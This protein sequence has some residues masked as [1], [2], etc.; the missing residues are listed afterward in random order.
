MKTYLSPLFLLV[1]LISMINP[2]LAGE[3]VN[4]TKHFNHASG[5][6]DLGLTGE[7]FGDLKNVYKIPVVLD[8]VPDN[9]FIN[10][11][12]VVITTGV[13]HVSYDPTEIFLN[14]ESIKE[15]DFRELDEGS[16]QNIR[17]SL[18][19]EHLTVGR[20]TIKIIS[21]QCNE[22]LDSMKFNGVT[23]SIDKSSS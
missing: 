13:C 3:T 9:A 22:G 21:G 7:K 10:M 2:A 20:N 18:P 4:H 19:K 8:E 6:V 14:G 11:K 5:F 17:V 15:I 23:L 16:K 1:S 12:F